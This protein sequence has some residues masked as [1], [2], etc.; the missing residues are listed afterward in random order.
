MHS[1]RA[2][3][4]IKGDNRQGGSLRQTRRRAIM[5]HSRFMPIAY[6]SDVT[7]D[8]LRAPSLVSIAIHAHPIKR[9]AT[10]VPA[11]M[12]PSPRLLPPLL[13]SPL[14]PNNELYERTL[15]HSPRAHPCRRDEHRRGYR[16]VVVEADS[17]RYTPTAV[18]R[19]RKTKAS[20]GAMIHGRD[21]LFDDNE[22]WG[23]TKYSPRLVMSRCSR[24]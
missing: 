10:R 15:P 16:L 11:L 9:S 6:L 20:R 19:R 4:G 3:A 23:N 12:N 17:A 7:S 2:P 21:A 14:S 18:S 22:S 8:L 1:D 13:P 24:N 5:R